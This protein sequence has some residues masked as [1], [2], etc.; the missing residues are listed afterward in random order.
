MGRQPDGTWQTDVPVGANAPQALLQQ[1]L[2]HVPPGVPVQTVPAGE[3]PP[4][5]LPAEVV[6]TPT[7]LPA[8]M[9]QKPV[10][11]SVLPRHESFVCLQ[12]EE[13]SQ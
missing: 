5:P 6:Q 13:T 1:F 12:N 8:P 10:Q 7:V 11:H 9:E 2:S 4:V 3:Q